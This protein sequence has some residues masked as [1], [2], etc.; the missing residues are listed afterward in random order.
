M[1]VD[2]L[3]DIAVTYALIVA[4]ATM[5]IG[6]YFLIVGIVNPAYLEPAPRAYMSPYA[7]ARY[8]RYGEPGGVYELPP[9][10][11]G[12]QVTVSLETMAGDCIHCGADLAGTSRVLCCDA[13]A[14]IFVSSATYEGARDRFLRRGMDGDGI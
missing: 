11:K 5:A 8:A 13:C 12:N 4:W 10:A 2:T 1:M 9:T 14:A 7:G 6:A 3:I